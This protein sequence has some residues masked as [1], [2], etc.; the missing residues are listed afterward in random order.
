MIM[1][2]L[3]QEYATKIYAK[4]CEEKGEKRGEKRGQKRGQKIGEKIGKKIGKIEGAMEATVKMCQRFGATLEESIN[5]IAQD[6]GLSAENAA[7][8]VNKLWKN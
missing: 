6:F 2:V 8:Y 1:S 3:S 5:M 7:Q 4:E